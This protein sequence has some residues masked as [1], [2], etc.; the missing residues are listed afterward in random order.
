MVSGNLCIGSFN[1][2]TLIDPGA[3]H[4]F[5]NLDTVLR[6]GLMV[7]SLECPLLINGPKCDPWV[8]EMIYYAYL[9]IIKNR[10]FQANLVVL[11]L[12]DFDIILGMD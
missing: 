3:S 6:L 10:S 4:S 1:V 7:S 8:T 2:H 12:I 5:V 11:E 9:V